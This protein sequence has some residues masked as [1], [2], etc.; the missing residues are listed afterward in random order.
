MPFFLIAVWFLVI[1]LSRSYSYSYNLGFKNA[2]QL[3]RIG[4]LGAMSMA[5]CPAGLAQNLLWERLYGTEKVDHVSQ[6]MTT[7][8]QHQVVYGH[9][10]QDVKYYPGTTHLHVTQFDTGG[11]LVWQQAFPFDGFVK[12]GDII[13]SHD[14]GYLL[15]ATLRKPDQYHN[16]VWKLN[17]DGK[18]VWKKTFGGKQ[19]HAPWLAAPTSDSAFFITGKPTIDSRYNEQNLEWSEKGL[20]VLKLNNQGEL[21]HKNNLGYKKTLQPISLS[22]IDQRT[23]SIVA[24]RGQRVFWVKADK[25]EGQLLLDQLKP[26]GL[27]NGDYQNLTVNTVYQTSDN[28]WLL[29]GAVYEKNRK[30]GPHGWLS[31]INEAGEVQWQAVYAHEE[32][33][34]VHAVARLSGLGLVFGGHSRKD[35]GSIDLAEENS[36][37]GGTNANGKLQWEQFYGGKAADQVVDLRTM[38]EAGAYFA[39]EATHSRLSSSDQAIDQQAWRLRKLDTSGFHQPKPVRAFQPYSQDTSYRG[40]AQLL[41]A[42]R[43]QPSNR[44]LNK[45]LYRHNLIANPSLSSK[46]APAG[47]SD[48]R[49]HRNKLS[50]DTFSRNLF[51]SSRPEVIVQLRSKRTH[52]I[53]VFYRKGSRLHKVPGRISHHLSDQ[54]QTGDF[55]FYFKSIGSPNAYEI[56]TKR[57]WTYNRSNN[58]IISFYEVIPDTI[59]QFYDVRTKAFSYSG[60]QTY[61]YDTKREIE[62]QLKDSFPK[63]LL[64]HAKTN[65]KTDMDRNKQGEV[66]SGKQEQS[67]AKKVVTFVKTRRGLRIS[68]IQKDLTETIEILGIGND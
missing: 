59:R 17:E 30:N 37:I 54:Y 38:P 60:L 29:G 6:L 66:L 33:N 16:L 46:R 21:E 34:A 15:T 8:N 63:Q 10:H 18:P 23:Y 45:L 12:A 5:C 2:F 53:A 25:V 43:A 36:W 39:L 57:Q 13:S 26:L 68:Q 35:R 31:K 41:Q 47:T 27:P 24:T 9:S 22:R 42:I 52:D 55:V 4:L 11:Q 40:I 3:F 1:G 32:A 48:W 62:W 65:N 14:G 44:A 51:G 56:A 64:I 7:D 28:H 20:F 61:S 67:T 49:Y 50:I 58:E 19:G